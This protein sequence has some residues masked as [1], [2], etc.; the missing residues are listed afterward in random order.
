M[1]ILDSY[2]FYGFFYMLDELFEPLA[3]TVFPIFFSLLVF[4][5][6]LSLSAYFPTLNSFLK[7]IYHV[8][9]IVLQPNYFLEQDMSCAEVQEYSPVS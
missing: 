9:V 3:I 7:I 8:R 4:S 6:P 1:S 2:I 5:L